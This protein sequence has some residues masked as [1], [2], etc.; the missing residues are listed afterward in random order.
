MGQIKIFSEIFHSG[1]AGSREI[2]FLCLNCMKV[3]DVSVVMY[4]PHTA[5]H[6]VW[7]DVT[8]ENLT[9]LIFPLYPLEIVTYH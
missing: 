7:L 2:T 8:I 4:F 3:F 1:T 6:V 9:A 5:I